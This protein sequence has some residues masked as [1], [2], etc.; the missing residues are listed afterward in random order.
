MPGGPPESKPSVDHKFTSSQLAPLPNGI[1]TLPLK[2]S[3]RAPLFPFNDENLGAFDQYR[4]IR[5]KIFQHILAPR[6]IVVSSAAPKD[7]KTV[8]SVNLAG[9]MALKQDVRVL[10]VEADLHRGDIKSLL[11]FEPAIGLVDVLKGNCTYGEALIKVEQ[12]PNLYVLLSGR[13]DSSATEL[14]D[15]TAWKRL[16]ESWKEQ[17]SYIIVDS[18]PW[19]ILADADLLAASSDGIVFVVRPDRT[20]RS[21]ALTALN[22]IPKDKL[23]G[24]IVNSAQ[25]WILHRSSY[26]YY[27]GYYNS[28]PQE[29]RSQGGPDELKQ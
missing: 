17:F 18:P 13:A 15:S 9:V 12:I 5:T 19:G 26:S 16:C 22:D 4:I 8:T 23:L 10:L 21:M 27:S 7:G 25:D 14:L 24:V 29:E 2:V 20:K 11:G 1:R 6:Q 3:S 28:H